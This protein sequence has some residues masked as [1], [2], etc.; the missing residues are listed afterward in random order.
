M[1]ASECD[2]DHEELYTDYEQTPQVPS[3]Q[4]EELSQQ[5]ESTGYFCSECEKEIK[6]N[7]YTYYLNKFG[8]PLCMKCQKGAGK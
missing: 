2:V 7:V 6:E 5:E 3:G 8:R 4:G 1:F